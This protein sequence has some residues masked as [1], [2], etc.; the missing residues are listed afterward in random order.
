M[1]PQFESVVNVSEGRRA[2]VVDR[3]VRQLTTHPGVALLD[4]SSDSAHN[5]SVFTMA[6]PANPLLDTLLAFTREAVASID[7]RT[8]HGVHPRLG[9]VNVVP[10]IPLGD[11]T[12]ADAVALARLVGRR[13]AQDLSI[14]VYLYEEAA[15]APHRRHLEQIRRGGLEGLVARLTD[16]G[17]APDFG[18]LLPHP[19]AG[20]TI[21]GA[22]FFLIA[23]NVLL[24]SSDLGVA[25]AIA[26]AVRERGGGLPRVKALGLA[27]ADRD[28]VQ[29]SMN[30]VDYRVTGIRAAFDRVVLEA[31]RRG[32]DVSGSELIGL[33][34]ADALDDSLARHVRLANFSDAKILERRLATSAAG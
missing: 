14:P 26:A 9:A 12:M 6:G 32:V 16:P 34:P 21:V 15:S 4:Y 19:T 24:N 3:L 13:I 18:P 30:L 29:V 28:M 31:A 23:Y 25:R 8:H 5:R 7:L 1:S 2:D 17:W 33:A 10:F 11:A 20:V 27:L 22:R